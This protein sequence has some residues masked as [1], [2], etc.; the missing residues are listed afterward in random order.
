MQKEMEALKKEIVQLEE[1]LRSK[2]DAV[3]CA[4]TRL[5]MRAHRPGFELCK[6]EAE[7]GLR[8]EVLQ[9]KQ[10]EEDLIKAIERA[11]YVFDITI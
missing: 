11:K 7:S 9:L 2:A 10:T 4:E 6:D 8:N 3:K 5:E 1:A